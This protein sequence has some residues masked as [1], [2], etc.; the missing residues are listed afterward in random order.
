MIPYASRNLHI[1]HISAHAFSHIEDGSE[2]WVVGLEALKLNIQ[3]QISFLPWTHQVALE[4]PLP[5]LSDSIPHLQY[6]NILGLSYG[7]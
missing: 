1:L 3:I 6:D 4:K 7:L 2:I 5:P